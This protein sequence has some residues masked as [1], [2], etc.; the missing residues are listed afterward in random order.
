[1]DPNT[2]LAIIALVAAALLIDIA[3]PQRGT[4]SWDNKRAATQKDVDEVFK[5]RGP[6]QSGPRALPLVALLVVVFGIAVMFGR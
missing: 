5:G 1:M 2:T 3:L 6:A 4:R